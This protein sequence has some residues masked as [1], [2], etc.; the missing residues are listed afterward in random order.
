MPLIDIKCEAGHISEVMRP[1]KDW[2]STPACPDCGAT[3][4]QV[5]L[6]PQRRYAQ[7]DP[8]V[9]FRAPDGSFRFPGDA[10]GAGAARYARE[11][12]ERIEL[13]SAADV[14][15]FESHMN[16]RELSRASRR[17]EAM[18]ANREAREAVNRSELR[19]LMPNMT[20]FGRAVA[21]QAM[22]RNDAKPR[23]R[24]V[25]VGFHVEAFSYDRSNREEARGPDGRRRRD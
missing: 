24:A 14:R 13:R 16:K 11:G 22:A 5:F 21:R 25:D 19:R 6:P 9:V 10:N 17:V 15:R 1:D 3:T 18:Q 20:E 8:V 4:E 7:C 23:E 2:P 12:L